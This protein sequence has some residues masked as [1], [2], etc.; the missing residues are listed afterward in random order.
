MY[1][2]FT[3][4]KAWNFLGTWNGS[5]KEVYLPGLGF[6][7]LSIPGFLTRKILLSEEIWVRETGIFMS[8]ESVLAAVK[9]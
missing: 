6:R 7:N 5:T 2:K 1:Q 4:D 8:D 3:K 9:A